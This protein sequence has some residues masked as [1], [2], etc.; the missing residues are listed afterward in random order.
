MLACEVNLFGKEA[1]WGMTHQCQK[2][3]APPKSH[4]FSAD[5]A[6]ADAIRTYSFRNVRTKSKL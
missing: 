2:V 3:K 1:T 4:F 5:V 6:T